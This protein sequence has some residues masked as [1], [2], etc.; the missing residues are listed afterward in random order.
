MNCGD[1]KFWNGLREGLIS[2]WPEKLLATSG[3]NKDTKFV[4]TKLL[5]SVMGG[6]EDLMEFL[7]SQPARSMLRQYDIEFGGR[8]DKVYRELTNLPYF[9]LPPIDW[10]QYQVQPEVVGEGEVDAMELDMS[11]ITIVDES[12]SNDHY[13][14]SEGEGDQ[15]ML[16]DDS[17]SAGSARGS[18]AQPVAPHLAA[19]LPAPLAA[20]PPVDGQHGHDVS[21]DIDDD[22][23]EF[24]DPAAGA[25]P[26]PTNRGGRP[27]KQK[28]N[29]GPQ[30]DW[31]FQKSAAVA[32]GNEFK[33]HWYQNKYRRQ[34]AG[35]A[36]N[37]EI[38][39]LYLLRCDEMAS[40]VTSRFER[41]EVLELKKR[42]TDYQKTVSALHIQLDSSAM[43]STITK[44]QKRGQVFIAHLDSTDAEIKGVLTTQFP[45]AHVDK[46]QADIA[47]RGRRGAA[48]TKPFRLALAASVLLSFVTT[49]FQ[50]H[51]LGKRRRNDEVAPASASL[52]QV[53]TWC[54]E[55]SPAF[56]SDILSHFLDNATLRDTIARRLCVVADLKCISVRSMLVISDE[57]YEAGVD[58][59]SEYA[60]TKYHKLLFIA[61]VQ[62]FGL[63]VAPD[64]NLHHVDMTQL[65]VDLI[66][67]RPDLYP[68][69]T[70]AS[71]A[72]YVEVIFMTDASSLK[73]R[74][75]SF[76]GLRPQHSQSFRDALAVCWYQ[77]P[78]TTA[79]Y[80]Q[81]FSTFFGQVDELIVN[82]LDVDQ[83][84]ICVHGVVAQDW[85]AQCQAFDRC[86]TSFCLYCLQDKSTRCLKHKPCKRCVARG[87]TKLCRHCDIF[88]RKPTPPPLL[89]CY[90]LQHG[91]VPPTTST[92]LK[93]DELVKWCNAYLD[94]TRVDPTQLA[95]GR[96]RAAPRHVANVKMPSIGDA[97]PFS[98]HK[99]E[100][101]RAVYDELSDKNTV[102]L[103]ERYAGDE[104]YV[105]NATRDRLVA[106]LL[107][108]YTAHDISAKFITA[109]ATSPATEIEVL[110]GLLD[111][112][113]MHEFLTSLH[114]RQPPDNAF[115]KD[116]LLV[117]ACLLHCFMRTAG[118]LVRLLGSAI[119]AAYDEAETEGCLKGVATVI[120]TQLK[121]DDENGSGAFTFE[122]SKGKKGQKSVAFELSGRELRQLFTKSDESV[123]INFVAAAFPNDAVERESWTTLFCAYREIIIEISKGEYVKDAGGVATTELYWT[124]EKIWG[125]QD[126][127]DQFGDLYLQKFDLSDVTPYF[128]MLIGGHITELMHKYGSW[129]KYQQQAWERVMG[130]VKCVILRVTRIL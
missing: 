63:V 93:K 70:D 4:A 21:S 26:P 20:E 42:I 12:N 120:N 25:E 37:E 86:G 115:V 121:T 102:S 108:R 34:L 113:L 24:Q 8:R 91:G 80:Q 53:I 126:M 73:K 68:I 72:E 59:Y 15:L 76:A 2:W 101:L 43:D 71:G 119:T 46:L 35:C 77:A 27:K 79:N 112:T 128:H 99:V 104:M 47:C 51:S 82:G 30:L 7:W 41:S 29:A 1:A 75:Y 110:R 123:V 107:F 109:S 125:V 124:A 89:P 45:D 69:L 87:L 11:K 97:N 13:L 90:K 14:D 48:A 94:I 117:M 95:D 5:S 78:D 74:S 31:S 118:K 116:P 18:D 17:G 62:K 65:L 22:G 44:Q 36:T 85:K 103:Y 58:L 64:R 106:S 16:F 19:P 61:A 60:I 100:L 33:K 56:G 122:V 23:Q 127:C 49:A 105:G 81:H 130:E 129:A 55:L 98:S 83:K 38:V 111:D 67:H 52:A 88:E 9:W 50:Q 114:T 3:F 32:A 6:D 57:L 96:L 28:V 40:A 92:N 66:R 39:E 10:C 54:G 84:H